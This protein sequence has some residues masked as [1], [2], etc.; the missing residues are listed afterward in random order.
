MFRTD[1]KHTRFKYASLSPVEDANE[2]SEADTQRT[3]GGRKIKP[4]LP[5]W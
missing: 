3:P 1:I 2:N 4:K 5:M